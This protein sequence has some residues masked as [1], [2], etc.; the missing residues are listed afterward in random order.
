MDLLTT[1][2]YNLKLQAITAPPLISTIHKSPQHPLSFLFHPTVSSQAVPWQRLLTVEIF[3]LHA[4]RSFLHRL[5]QR[6]G[7]VAPIIF[8]I[9]PRYG[10]S[11]KLRS[12]VACISVAA[13]TCKPSRCPETALLYPPISLSLHNN[14]CTRYSILPK[15]RIHRTCIH[16]HMH[17]LLIR[18]NRVCIDY[19]EFI[20]TARLRMS[21][22]C[23]CSCSLCLNVTY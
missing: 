22:V 21:S 23:Q 3:Q 13:G 16:Q 15:I 8:V 11:R 17:T 6:T 12:S 19:R 7:L 1:Y 5:P 4:L 2:T 20:P 10:P 14:G 18:G 9:T